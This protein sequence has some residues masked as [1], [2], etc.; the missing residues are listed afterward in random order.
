MLTSVDLTTAE[1]VQ[2]SRVDRWPIYRR[3]QELKI[4]C[5]CSEDGSLW[6]QIHD[7]PSALLLRSTV[8]QVVASRSELINWLEQC[9]NWRF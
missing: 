7:V 3:L 5:W 8:Q 6:V 1:R 2:V 4:P 9:W